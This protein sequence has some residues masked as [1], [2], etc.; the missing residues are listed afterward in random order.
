VLPPTH[1]VIPL[2]PRRRFS[3]DLSLSTERIGVAFQELK[4]LRSC[5]EQVICDLHWS[6]T[7]WR[8]ITAPLL[9]RLPRARK[10]LADL[11]GVELDQWPDT[12]WAVVLLAAR[13]EV[14]SRL[15]DVSMSIT[16][17]IT[18][19]TSGLDEVVNFGFDCT[20]LAEATGKL[21]RHI[22]SQYPGE[23]DDI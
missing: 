6:A 11:A 4:S 14:E 12:Y 3:G 7:G 21:C 5:V 13:A 16:S 1:N 9:P 2:H 15:L 23:I 18:E 8:V 22:A 17:L 19:E 20:K 10:S